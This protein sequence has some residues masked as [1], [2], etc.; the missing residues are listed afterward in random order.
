MVPSNDNTWS[1][2]KNN[3]FQV[4]RVT[5]GQNSFNSFIPQP[6]Y[7]TIERQYLVRRQELPSN[8]NT[9]SGG[10]NRKDWESTLG[11]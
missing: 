8:D 4:E 11:V 3:Q 1:G 7:G 2:G 5:R 6:K 10:R 9:W